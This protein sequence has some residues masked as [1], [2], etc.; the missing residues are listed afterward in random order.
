MKS[1]I[2]IKQMN[3]GQAMTEYILIVFVLSI[4][5]VLFFFL[6]SKP[7]F[8]Q[9]SISVGVFGAFCGGIAW[10]IKQIIHSL[11]RRSELLILELL[12]QNK[13]LDRNEIQI[14]IVK[15]SFVFRLLPGM[16]TDALAS[17]S[18]SGKLAIEDGKFFIPNNICTQ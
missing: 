15:E 13:P 17:L 3:E 2:N 7:V 10:G 18:V 11:N 9:K 16:H 5:L 8:A 6:M 1:K 12:S 4:G 14:R